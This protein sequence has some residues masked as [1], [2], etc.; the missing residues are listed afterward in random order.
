[1]HRKRI[2]TTGLIALGAVLSLFGGCRLDMHDQPKYES[3]EASSF[4]PDGSASRIPPEGT[5]AQGHLRDDELLYTG[6]LDGADSELFPFPVTR[7]VL[8]RGQ[9]RFDIYCSPCHDRVGTGHGVIVRRGMKQPPSFHIVRLKE[10]P[11]GY[12]YNVITNGFGVMFSYASRISPE[13]RWAIIAY[14]R[15]LQLSQGASY[16]DV[17]QEDLAKLEKS[18]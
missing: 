15:A 6:R 3:L 1:M 18:N 13:D 2:T 5:V 4:F 16:G 10:A 12:F 17:P 7:K 9:E 8:D 14:I 11:P